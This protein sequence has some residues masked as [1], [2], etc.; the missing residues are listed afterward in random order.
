[1]FVDLSYTKTNLTSVNFIN[2]FKDVK[3]EEKDAPKTEYQTRKK[4]RVNRLQYC[5][6]LKK[7]Q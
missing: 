7:S 2:E 1:M 3:D 4:L 6:S 5:A